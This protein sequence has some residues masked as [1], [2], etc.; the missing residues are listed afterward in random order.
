VGGSCSA[1]EPG[2]DDDAL[3]PRLLLA[4]PEI[5]VGAGFTM[6]TGGYTDMHMFKMTGGD[7]HAVDAIL[8]SAGGSGW[9]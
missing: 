5:G 4:D 2:P 1:E 9:D 7:V 8:G 3:T 6:F